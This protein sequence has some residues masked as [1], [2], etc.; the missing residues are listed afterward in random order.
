MIVADEHRT[1]RTDSRTSSENGPVPPQPVVFSFD[2]EEHH[3]I[4][5][6]A[7]L[8]CSE[9]LKSTYRDRMERTTR[10]LLELLGEYQIRATFYIVGEI[11]KSHP[12]LV[13][14]IA[15]AGHE[16]GSHG[17]SHQRV[18]KLESKGF[19]E[20]LKQSRDALAEVS[21]QPILGFRA[22][23]FSIDHR[24]PWAIDTLA[25]LGFV[26]DSSIFPVRHDRY[27]V[28]EAPRVPFLVRGKERELIELPPMTYRLFSQNLPMAGGGY[29]RLFPL[30]FIRTGLSQIARIPGGLGMLYF[31][32]WEFDADQPKLPLNRLSRWRTYVGISQSLQRLRSLLVQYRQNSCRAIDFVE[33]LRSTQQ[34]L[35]RFQLTQPGELHKA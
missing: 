7:N 28:P 8:S 32:P 34:K 25:E 12:Q 9:E 33:Q 27:G 13:R 1:R 21:G 2:V 19:R 18:L 35:S 3:R 24:T 16:I 10:Q 22:P 11:A 15:N 5:A 6:A 30:Q 31:H 20:D 23:T 17:W 26:Y 29:F 14:D 4:E